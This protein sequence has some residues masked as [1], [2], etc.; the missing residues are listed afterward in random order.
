MFARLAFGIAVNMRPEILVIDEVLAVGDASFQE[1]CFAALEDLKA[2]GTTILLV[3]HDADTVRRFCDRAALLVDGQLLDIGPANDVVDYY[4]RLLHTDQPSVRLL[5]VRA[6]DEL[7]LPVDSV[8]SGTPVTVEAL[9]RA[10]E[11]L[12]TAGLRLEIAF[13]RMGGS[14][15]WTTQ[16]ALPPEL[17]YA[18]TA[19][20]REHDLPDTRSARL[21]IDELPVAGDTLRLIATLTHGTDARGEL[22]DRQETLLEI[23]QRDPRQRGLLALDHHWDWEA[24]DQP[25]LERPHPQPLARGNGRGE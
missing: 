18:E 17:P 25:A 1:K 8:R 3:S 23:E 14:N 9:L 12:S 20:R 13:D 4:E 15:L 7:G 5:R 6:L 10:P 22:L 21:R 11:G 19:G 24:V 16:V 2:S